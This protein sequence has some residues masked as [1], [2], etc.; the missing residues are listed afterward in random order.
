MRRKIDQE[1][2]P[3]EEEYILYAC[4]FPDVRFCL[5]YVHVGNTELMNV[6]KLGTETVAKLSSYFA[7]TSPLFAAS[8]LQIPERHSSLLKTVIQ[9]VVPVY[10]C[11]LQ[12]TPWQ[13]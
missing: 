5:P 6:W 1:G 10:E 13:C 12:A 2:C 8:L 9:L 3:S 7:L 4:P 11:N